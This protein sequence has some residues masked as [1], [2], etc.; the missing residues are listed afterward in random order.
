MIRKK[1]KGMTARICHAARICHPRICHI[2]LPIDTMKT[3]TETCIGALSE[4]A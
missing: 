4:W 1:C 3:A 2:T